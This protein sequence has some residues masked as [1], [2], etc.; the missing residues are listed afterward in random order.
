MTP[1]EHYRQAE[2]IVENMN[3]MIAEGKVPNTPTYT[4]AIAM[5]QVHATLAC[6]GDPSRKRA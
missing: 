4:A 5:A 3:A 2:T 6:A 1:D